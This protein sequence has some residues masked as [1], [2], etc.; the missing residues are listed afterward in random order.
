MNN[1]NDNFQYL[2]NTQRRD[3]DFDTMDMT[4]VDLVTNF[5]RHKKNISFGCPLSDYRLINNNIYMFMMR[6]HPTCFFAIREDYSFV[7]GYQ[8]LKYLYRWM[9]KGEPAIKNDGTK[10]YYKDMPASFRSAFENQNVRVRVYSNSVSI[11]TFQQ[12]HYL[13]D[14]QIGDKALL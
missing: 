14:I 2:L 8:E 7:V 5:K 10:Y 12:R 3:L 4:L 11:N 9:F 13:N 1:S 6:I